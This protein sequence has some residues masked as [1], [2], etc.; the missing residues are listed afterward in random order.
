MNFYPN[1]AVDRITVESDQIGGTLRLID[2]SGKLL[3]EKQIRQYSETV[4]LNGVKSGVYFISLQNGN[5]RVTKKLIV[6]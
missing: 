2:I 1:P 5:E 4:E 6:R 3:L